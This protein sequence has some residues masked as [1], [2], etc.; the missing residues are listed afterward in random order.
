[1]KREELK[2]TLRFPVCVTWAKGHCEQKQPGE[3]RDYVETMIRKWFQT[4]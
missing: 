3:Q 4:R 2:T 1:M